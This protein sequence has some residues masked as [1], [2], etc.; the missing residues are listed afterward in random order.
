MVASYMHQMTKK[1]RLNGK[2]RDLTTINCKIKSLRQTNNKNNLER[3][4][5]ISISVT[6]DDDGNNIKLSFF[7]LP[8][9]Y[10]YYYYCHYFY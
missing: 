10:Y 6:I 2:I 7:I 3:F 8:T 5:S 1:T 9:R 4:K